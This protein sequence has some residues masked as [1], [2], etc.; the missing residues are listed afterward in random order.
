MDEGTVAA[1]VR[2]LRQMLVDRR[3]A[4]EEDVR[5]RIRQARTERPEP[6][7]DGDHSDTAMQ[8]GIAFAVI[9]LKT[10]T[11]ARIDAALVRLD[12]GTYGN[13]FEC[14]AEIS[15]KRLGALPFAAR[16]TAC[17]ETRE[18]QARTLKL[19]RKQAELTFFPPM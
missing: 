16:C 3:R 6:L 10:E 19:A 18:S 17:E 1:R 2:D 4:I 7:G 5:E 13:C 14:G 8:T 15:G 12:A 11:L 9:Q